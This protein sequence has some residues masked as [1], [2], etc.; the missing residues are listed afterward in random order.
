M[1]YLFPGK[2]KGNAIPKTWFWTD[3]RGR[4]RSICC[5]KSAAF[6]LLDLA[7]FAVRPSAQE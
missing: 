4:R 6:M 3:F 2:G 1:A 5:S 7:S